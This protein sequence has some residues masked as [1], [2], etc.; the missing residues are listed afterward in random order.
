MRHTPSELK[1]EAENRILAYIGG[2]RKE[3]Y[4]TTDIIEKCITHNVREDEFYIQGYHVG[5]ALKILERS[6]RVEKEWMKTDDGGYWAYH[7]KDKK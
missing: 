2:K 3:G 6:G 1:K 5:Q 4:S 7:L